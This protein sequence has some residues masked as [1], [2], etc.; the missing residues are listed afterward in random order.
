MGTLLV[1]VILVSEELHEK[2]LLSCE[3]HRQQSQ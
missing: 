1:L 2:S 3:S